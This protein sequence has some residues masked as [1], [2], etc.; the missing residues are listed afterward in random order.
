MPIEA[1]SNRGCEPLARGFCDR[2]VP[3]R[4]CGFMAGGRHTAAILATVIL[5]TPTR[6]V[7]FG[8]PHDDDLAVALSSGVAVL[9]LL[10]LA[11]RIFT[12][13]LTRSAHRSCRPLG[14]PEA[15]DDPST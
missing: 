10:E 8:P 7:H 9:L 6:L 2:R 11:K 3:A 4:E 13:M 5:F 15:A 14:N 1:P 12:P